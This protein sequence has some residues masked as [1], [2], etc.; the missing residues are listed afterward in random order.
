MSWPIKH[1]GAI[2]YASRAPHDGTISSSH[3]I[4][5]QKVRLRAEGL[6]DELFCGR[7]KTVATASIDQGQVRLMHSQCPTEAYFALFFTS[8]A[9][10]ICKPLGYTARERR[11]PDFFYLEASFR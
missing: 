8:E 6:F 10:G 9:P 2:P 7:V 3:R 5:R 11:E 4:D 1:S